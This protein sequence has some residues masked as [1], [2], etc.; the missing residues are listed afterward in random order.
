[1]RAVRRA[2]RYVQRLDPGWFRFEDD[3]QCVKSSRPRPRFG[4]ADPSLGMGRNPRHRRMNLRASDEQYRAQ[5]VDGDCC[6]RRLCRPK[7]R[8]TSSP[9]FR[10]LLSRL[11][12]LH[13]ARAPNFGPRSIGAARRSFLVIASH[14]ERLHNVPG[15]I[16]TGSGR[17][18]RAVF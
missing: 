12:D 2:A 6:A 4:D 5:G 15:Q 14:V 13:S 11:A 18:E 10:Q 1:M 7:P 8:S 16:R 9:I 3:E 17:Q